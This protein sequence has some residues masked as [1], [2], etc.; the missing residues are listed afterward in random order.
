MRRALDT[1]SHDLRTPL[2]RL[3]GS[4]E[5]ALGAPP[6]LDRYRQAPADVWLEAWDVTS[7]RTSSAS[8]L[9]ANVEMRPR[10][11]VRKPA[12]AG[13]GAPAFLRVPYLKDVDA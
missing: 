9:L 10:P 1:V 13:R 11:N 8:C 3:R 5:M 4:A 7:E 6:D 2:T 12:T